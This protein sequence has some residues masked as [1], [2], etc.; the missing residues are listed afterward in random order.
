MIYDIKN[1]GSFV[2]HDK[3]VRKSYIYNSLFEKRQKGLSVKSN[4]VSLKCLHRSY[5]KLKK[6]VS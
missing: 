3:N 4:G 1:S 6:I 5:S 2:R